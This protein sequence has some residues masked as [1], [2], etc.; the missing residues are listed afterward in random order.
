MI[1]RIKF[2]IQD[3]I[4]MMEYKY[5]PERLELARSRLS[6]HELAMSEGYQ[7]PYTDPDDYDLAWR[8]LVKRS[9]TKVDTDTPT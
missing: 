8:P 4:D 9:V 2:W 7:S 6:A 3:K 1:E 5:G